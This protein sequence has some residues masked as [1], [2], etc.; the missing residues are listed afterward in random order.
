M[1]AFTVTEVLRIHF[2]ASGAKC[3]D[4]NSKFRYQQ[5]GG[6]TS[7]DDAGLEF[8]R[9][10]PGIMKSLGVDNIFDLSPGIHLPY[11]LT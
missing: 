1:D 6:Y 5:R 8:R 2:L 4:S 11:C 10:E 7:M 9:N 3:S